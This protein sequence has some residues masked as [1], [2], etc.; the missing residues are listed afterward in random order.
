VRYA[1][2]FVVTGASKRVIQDCVKPAVVEFLKV[3]GLELNEEKTLVTNVKKGFDLVGFHFRVY[4]VTHKKGGYLCLVTPTK[5]GVLRMQSKVKEIVHQHKDR[6][7]YDLIKALN[8][9][10]MGW[11]NY[12]HKVSSS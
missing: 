9:V 10:L 12:Y 4:Q 2:D 1:D 8:P 7:A 3:R 6:S 11:A 5:S